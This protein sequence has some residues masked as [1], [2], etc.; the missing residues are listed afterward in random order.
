M[1]KMISKFCEVEEG[2][3]EYVQNFSDCF[4]GESG[5]MENQFIRSGFQSNTRPGT[6]TRI[7]QRGGDLNALYGD[8]KNV[9]FV[10]SEFSDSF[11]SYIEGAIRVSRKKAFSLINREDP[12]QGFIEKVNVVTKH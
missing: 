11:A 3:P 5:F 1:K 2:S 9:Y 7:L 6:F 8:E 10:G 4:I 12:L